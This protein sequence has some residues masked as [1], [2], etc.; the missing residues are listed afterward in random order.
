MLGSTPLATGAF[1]AVDIETTG[2]RPGSGAVLEVGAVRIEAG[3]VGASF[4][5]LVAPGEAI[6]PTIRHLTGIDDAMVADA[7][8]IDRVIAE[9]R[10]FVGDAVLVAHNHRFDM[11][12]L[13]YEAE[14]SWGMPFPR[15]VLDTLALARRLHPELGRHNLRSLAE[16]Y[17]IPA[18]PNHRALPDA[19]AT[20]EI[21]SRM[22][23]ELMALGMRTAAEAAAFCG[24]APEGALARKLSLATHLPDCQGVYLFRD[25]EGRV[26]YVGRAKNLRT[27]VRSHF[28]A[29]CGTP[30]AHPGPLTQR[31]DHIVCVSQLHAQLLETRLLERYRP[32]YNRERHG[33]RPPLYI[34]VSTDDDF[35]AL[36]VTRRRRR[37]GV[38]FGPVSN[39]WAARTLASTLVSHYSL[40]RCTGPL[41]R[42]AQ[43]PCR[44]RGTGTC[45]E[46]CLT[47]V[48]PSAYRRRVNAAIGVFNGAGPRF[49]SALV[50]L[51]Q[52]AAAGQRYEDAIAYRDAV[53]A[54]D[55]TLATL[56]LVE[57]SRR[58]AVTVLVEGGPEGVAAI[59]LA[60][61]A[62]HTVLRF[63]PDQVASGAAEPIVARA[64]GRALRR[65]DSARA[66]TPR[67]L[68]E[69]AI[70]DA[71]RKQQAPPA[72]AISDDGP[73]AVAGVCALLRKA[74][75]VP[76]KRHATHAT[77]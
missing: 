28:Y 45:P 18:T 53:R 21:F 76:R 55:R 65:A 51:Q 47:A 61:G 42:A 62:L 54:L 44:V 39:E 34:H 66:V 35:P 26:L 63:T 23:D 43:R 1:V 56:D 41:E 71:Y 14:R 30:A 64:L 70:V 5:S 49:R 75:R 22:L 8:P 37:S 69:I 46:P 52:R 77:A 31:V 74:I 67:V 2:C 6:P 68:R 33:A 24:V 4:S 60:R 20:A 9:F 12:F 11:G 58:D 25:S 3:R 36:C 32:P 15:P 50:T 16:H 19:L 7:P 73:Q 48:T 29:P 72:L 59:I 57:R 10:D 13:D 17:G 38:L 27:R 40:R